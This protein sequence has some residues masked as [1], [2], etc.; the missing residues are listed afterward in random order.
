MKKALGD[1]CV[2]TE[3]PFDYQLITNRGVVAIERKKFPIDFFAS[4]NDGRMAKECAAMR[5]VAEFR[6]IIAEGKLH[7]NR[8]TGMIRL[9]RKR[10]SHFTIPGLHNLVRSLKYVEGCDVE[11]SRNPDDT[12]KLLSEIQAYFDEDNHFSMRTLPRIAVDMYFPTYEEQLVGW[13]QRCGSDIGI[14]K[15]RE[16]AKVFKSPTDMFCAGVE[17]LV[18]V[19]GIGSKTAEKIYTFLHGSNG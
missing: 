9:S 11:W 10:D 6:F 1:M 17:D 7:L 18:K 19:P 8:K 16:L 2:P 4:V 15:A 13:L 14:I 3:L 12:V 5:G